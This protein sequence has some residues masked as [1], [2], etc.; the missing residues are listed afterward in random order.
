MT[1]KNSKKVKII[2]F[3]GYSGSG[4]TTL[5]VKILHA[6]KEKKIIA[7]VI[8]QSQQKTTIDQFGKDTHL[9]SEAGALPVVFKGILETVIFGREMEIHDLIEH[10]IKIYHPDII[11]VEGARDE[12]IPKIRIGD[13]PLREN[14]IKTYDGNIDTI[15][16]L[17][18]NGES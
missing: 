9:F 16:E 2:G 10:I 11:L 8:K 12:S 14:T 15:I 4:K 6:L 7:A 18:T 13:I 1:I 3:Y 17:I 5:I